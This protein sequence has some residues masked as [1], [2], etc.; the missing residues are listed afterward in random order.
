MGHPS[1]TF[2][3]PN[4]NVIRGTVSGRF[5]KEIVL[6]ATGIAAIGDC[7][8]GYSVLMLD[9]KMSHEWLAETLGEGNFLNLLPCVN[10]SKGNIYTH[11]METTPKGEGH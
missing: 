11:E 5:F 7:R 9:L 1:R 10:T 6:S 2:W 8:P 3:G 4:Y